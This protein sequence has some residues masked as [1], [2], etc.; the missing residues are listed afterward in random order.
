MKKILSGNLFFTLILIAL[1][2]LVPYIAPPFYVYLTLTSLAYIPVVIGFNILFGYT[3]LLSFGHGLFLAL[4]MYTTAFLM[5]NY[6][7]ENLEVLIL[8]SALSAFIVGLGVG[9]ICVKYT[10]IYFALLTLAFGMVFYTLLIKF[11]PITGGD[12]GLRITFKPLLLGL[13]FRYLPHLDFLFQPY[14]YYVLGIVIILTVLAYIIVSSHFGLSLKAI[15]ENSEKAEALGIN[16]KRFR[17][18]SFVISAIYTSIGGALLA[19]ITSH[20]TPIF[21]Y[22]TTSGEIVFMTLLGGFT[23]FFGPIIGVFVYTLLRD[24]IMSTIIYWRI[25]FGAALLLIIIFVPG[26]ISEGL[27]RIYKH[28]KGA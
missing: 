14:Y 23:N 25:L 12:E 9:Y 1:L 24:F 3:G 20:V 8:A 10:R 21:S 7:M 4:G 22:W 18:Y 16:I 27:I 6:T 2:A 26:G 19:H 11:T 28:F 15:K 5:R 17:L 13:D